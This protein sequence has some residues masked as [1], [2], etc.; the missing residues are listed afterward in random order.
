MNKSIAGSSFHGLGSTLSAIETSMNKR[1]NQFLENDNLILSTFLD[2]RYKSSLFSKSDPL[3]STKN[4]KEMLVQAHIKRKEIMEDTRLIMASS[5]EEESVVF[6]PLET[7]AVETEADEINLDNF[8]DIVAAEAEKDD[9]PSVSDIDP[10]LPVEC[11]PRTKRSKTASKRKRHSSS[12]NTSIDGETNVFLSHD[13]LDKNEDPL[14]WWK[15]HSSSMSLLSSL[16][17]KYLSAP[18]SSVES[19]RLFSIGGNIYTPHRNSL[20]TESGER[21]MFINYNLRIIDYSVSYKALE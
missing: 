19:E 12:I 15:T 14:T 2:P 3:M 5:S 1:F 18:P 6:H 17:T 16:A 9:S 10:P 7:P 13:L 21:L 20:K 8:F 4:I 11:D